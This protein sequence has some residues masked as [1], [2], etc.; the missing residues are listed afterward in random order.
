VDDAIP[1]DCEGATELGTLDVG[2]ML[3][4]MGKLPTLVDEDWYA[5]DVPAGFVDPLMAGGGAPRVTLDSGDAT[6]VMEI[7][8]RCSAALACNESTARELLEWSFVDDQSAEGA[9][10]YSTRDVAWPERVMIKVSRRGG[11]A[12]C[13]DYTL[14][15]TR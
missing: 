2:G 4:V 11:P 10:A 13:E 12:T 15:L 14:N 6:M 9:G 5:V 8:M 7:R 3:S 1:D